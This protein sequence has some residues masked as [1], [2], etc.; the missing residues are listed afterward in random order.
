MGIYSIGDKV[1]NGDMLEEIYGKKVESRK[2]TLLIDINLND[3]EQKKFWEYV[4]Q[5]KIININE[6]LKEMLIGGNN[7][8]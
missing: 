8:C 7:E 5:H 2:F 1:F 3:D 4:R 6:H